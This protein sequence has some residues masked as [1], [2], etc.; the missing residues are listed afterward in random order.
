MGSKKYIFL[1]V[2]TAAVLLLLALN[3]CRNIIAETV[4]TEV[5]SISEKEEEQEAIPREVQDLI[6]E[7]DSLYSDGLYSEANKAYR[8]AILEVEKLDTADK[9][10]ILSELDGRY[11]ETK[12][13][14]DTAR[15][16]HGNA[17]KLQYEK[18][19]EEALQELEMALEVYP[20]YQPAIDAMETLKA[21]EGLQ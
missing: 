12:E 16:H 14:V 10:A 18:R 3:G 7:A 19:F 15:M 11:E 4:V 20:K 5:E 21:L 9:E 6:D 13:I 8:S 2:L 17:M 1:A